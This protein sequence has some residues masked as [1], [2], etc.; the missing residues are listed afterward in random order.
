[1]H[2]PRDFR[3]VKAKNLSRIV[4][5]KVAFEMRNHLLSQVVEQLGMLIVGDIVEIDQPAHDVVFQALLVDTPA[6]ETD[7]IDLLSAQ[8]PNPKLVVR[9]RIV[10]CRQIQRE[11]FKP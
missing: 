5:G 3:L 4:D 6:T 9:R 7:Y 1:M 8:M 2:K 11:W 10:D